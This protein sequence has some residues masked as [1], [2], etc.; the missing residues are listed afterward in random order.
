VPAL[1]FM[2]RTVSRGAS[3]AVRPVGG[4]ALTYISYYLS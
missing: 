1:T 2:M 4:I 3:A